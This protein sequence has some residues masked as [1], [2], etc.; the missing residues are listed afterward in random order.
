MPQDPEY[1]DS[2]AT[3]LRDTRNL[4]GGVF[5]LLG[6]GARAGYEGVKSGLGSVLPG[7]AKVPGYLG[8][9]TRQ[10]GRALNNVVPQG[11]QP[12]ILDLIANSN[13]MVAGLTADARNPA[14][15]NPSQ[16]DEM[17][18]LLRQQLYNHVTN[19]VSKNQYTPGNYMQLDRMLT[20]AQQRGFNP[21]ALTGLVDYIGSKGKAGTVSGLTNSDYRIANTRP[22]KRGEAGYVPYNPEGTS[23]SASM[24]GVSAAPFNPYDT[25]LRA[26]PF[27]KAG[28]MGIR[29]AIGSKNPAIS[30]LAKRATFYGTKQAVKSV[31]KK[32][33]GAVTK[34]ANKRFGL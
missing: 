15:A 34:T 11:L 32:A 13:P 22:A 30:N 16:D 29:A 8:Y 17:A 24:P 3:T 33:L 20:E 5:D 4:A 18:L 9:Q 27:A 26:I 2:G 19:M 21:S 10:A 14:P 7:L 31:G 1:I 23:H 12:D 6:S 28:G 25:I